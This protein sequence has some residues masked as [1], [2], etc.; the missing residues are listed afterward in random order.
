MFFYPPATPDPCHPNPCQNGAPCY[1]NK[2]IYICLCHGRFS[3]TNCGMYS[4]YKKGSHLK[5][6]NAQGSINVL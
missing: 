2:G 3:G 4:K 6:Y 5:F 1:R